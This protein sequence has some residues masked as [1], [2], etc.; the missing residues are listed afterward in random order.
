MKNSSIM[1]FGLLVILAFF[2][3][4]CSTGTNSSSVQTEEVTMIA[5]TVEVTEEIIPTNPEMTSEE[6]II[7]EETEVITAEPAYSS[8]TEAIVHQTQPGAPVYTQSIT[9]E[10]NTGYNFN[11]DNFDVQPPCDSW[12]INLLE[13]AVSADLSQF[14]HYLDI[15]SARA[16]MSDGWIYLSMELFGAGVPTDGIEYTYFFEIDR[17]QNGRG[18]LLVSATNLDLYGTDWTV[19]GVRA[20]Q[21]LN[22]D[23]GGITAVR[24]DG[25]PGADG[26]ETKVFEEG[27][28]DDPDLVWVRRNPTLSNRIEF[29]FKPELLGTDLNFMWWAGAMRGEFDPQAFDLVDSQNSE[30]FFEIDTTCGMVYGREGAYNIKRCYVAPVPTPTVHSQQHQEQPTE[31][32]TEE[33]CVQPPHPDPQNNCWVWFPDDCEWVCIN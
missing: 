28:G 20:Q 25:S 9:S 17:D 14:Y 11:S 31:Q 21:D 7:W 8:P 24:A 2:V 33:V 1:L 5:E 19:T 6:T 3:D 30:E 23:V 15:L 29:A 26:Y 4:G 22:G 13:R 18:D 16:G 27:Y 32:P 10:C 12:N